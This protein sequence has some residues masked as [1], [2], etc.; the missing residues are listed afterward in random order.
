MAEE[1]TNNEELAEEFSVDQTGVP[2]EGASV[3]SITLRELDKIAQI[4]DFA[5]QRGA[6]EVEKCPCRHSLR[7]IGNIHRM[8]K[9]YQ[10]GQKSRVQEVT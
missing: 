4:I 6:S 1:V 2:E 10:D 7:Q 3:E 5:S 8:L 9:T